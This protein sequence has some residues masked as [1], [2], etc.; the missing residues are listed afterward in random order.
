MNQNSANR[1]SRPR[2]L[3][4]ATG[5]GIGGSGL[6]AVAHE[7]LR[8][9]R[10]GGFLGRAVCYGCTASDIPR[11][12]VDDLRYHPVKILRILPRRYYSGAKKAVADGHAARLLAGG[13]FDLFH[14]WS[15]DAV[16]C[17]RA[18]AQA[19]IPS[20]LEIPTWHRNKGK[21]KPDVTMSERQRDEAPLPARWLNS[22]LVTR[23]QV[24]EEYRLATL[25]LVLSEKARETFRIAGFP[26]D[27]LFMMH[28][29]VDPER[30]TPAASP[31]PAFRAI[32]V[33]ALLRRKGVPLLL[34]AW[35]EAALPGAELE[36]VGAVQPEVRAA[37]E[38]FADSSVKFPGHVRDVA[39]RLRNASIHVF[40]SELEGSAKATYEAAACGL[41][42]ITTRE[43]GDVVI[44]G[45]TGWVIPA[46]DPAA[47]V[48][49]LRAAYSDP[50]RL[51]Q[52]G[53]AARERVINHFTWKHFRERLGQAYETAIAR[54][55]DASPRHFHLNS[56]ILT[57]G[58]NG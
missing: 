3:L 48:A 16:R 29:G 33:G 40:P 54:A 17:L 13:G 6:D 18:A 46:K 36:L 52:M 51:L 41:P 30:F 45:K 26:D 23:Q 10:D 1:Q 34:E 35:R 28:R 37:I 19:G 27:K 56:D 38:R 39:A 4:Y 49:A 21:R 20:V 58:E 2:S 15:G 14:G 22:L 9:A 12:R 11:E 25:L 55:A 47:L 7:S 53:A 24:M 42:Q 32:F 5:A 31:P 57:S 44:D 43:A 50:A 8:L